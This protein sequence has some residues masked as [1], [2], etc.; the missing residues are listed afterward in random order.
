MEKAK[1]KDSIPADRIRISDIAS[2]LGVSTATVSNVIHG[3]T[4][5][6]SRRTFER[7]QKCLEESGYVPNMAAILLAQNSS[8]IV[9]VLLSDDVK[10]KKRMLQDPFVSGMVDGLSKY[11]PQYG[12]FMMLREEKEVDRI[13]QYASM[14]NMAGLILIGYCLQD[15]DGLRKKIRIPFLVLDGYSNPN[16]QW[17]D[18]MI[19]NY[20]GG[21]QVGEYLF[22]CGHRKI[23]YLSDNDECCDH[24][25]YQGCFDIY[26]KHGIELSR[27]GFWMLSLEERKRKS[28]YEM[29]RANLDSYTAAF[30]ASDL[31]AIEFMNDLLD[32]GK[33]VPEDL[34]IVGFDDV[35]AASLVRPKLTTV[36]QDLSE[37]ARMACEVLHTMIEEKT[38]PRNLVMPVKLVERESVRVLDTTITNGKSGVIN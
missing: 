21:A 8:R 35:P 3:K 4:G 18:I 13:V 15:F 29:I 22:R 20:S 36:N 5:K 38:A 16:E 2:Q 25:R 10:Y 27:D 34:S 7:V 28:Q 11:L 32:H 24:D 19:D 17:S 31:Y 12:Y 23:L 37:R 26:Q 30:C 6:I 1:N 33:R 9:C 14:W